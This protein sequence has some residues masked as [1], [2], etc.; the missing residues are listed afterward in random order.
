MVTGIAVICSSLTQAQWNNC[1]FTNVL[2]Y[3]PFLGTARNQGATNIHG[4]DFHGTVVGAQSSAD[5]F[6]NPLSAYSFN[7]ISDYIH[8]GNSLKPTFPFT[9]AM[10]VKR[11]SDNRSMGIFSSGPWDTSYYGVHIVVRQRGDARVDIG[12][13]G[14]AGPSSRRSKFV[15]SSSNF[16]TTNQWHHLAFVCASINNVEIYVDGALRQSDWTSGTGSGVK[17]T[18]SP[19]Q[20][21]WSNAGGEPNQH[22]DGSIDDF[23]VFNRALSTL[24]VVGLYNS[25]DPALLDSDGDSYDDREEVMSGMSPCN[26]DE[27]PAAHLGNYQRMLRLDLRP[28]DITDFTIARWTNLRDVGVISEPYKEKPPIYVPFDETGSGFFRSAEAT[29]LIISHAFK[30][31]FATTVGTSY[32]VQNSYDTVLWTNYSSPVLGNNDNQSVF[33]SPVP[34][35]HF[36]R[37]ISP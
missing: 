17:Y 9:I 24:D 26:P 2:G 25:A 28:T 3:Y 1:N 29:Y 6:G 36:F 19:A 20:I 8:F 12:D 13:G 21:G 10:W 37:V 33:G 22:F 32:Q 16:I 27:H 18:T 31:S 15:V 4:I 5:R 11:H 23:V 30:F 14:A 7:G 34:D 35:P